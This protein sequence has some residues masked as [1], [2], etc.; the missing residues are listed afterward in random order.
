MGTNWFH[1]K[2]ASIALGAAVTL[3]PTDST[4][5]YLLTKAYLNLK[6]YETSKKIFKQASL[7]EENCFDRELINNV[8]TE[9]KKIL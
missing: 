3:D 5:L 7:C 8:E 6:D 4:A 1:Y 9:M 2:N